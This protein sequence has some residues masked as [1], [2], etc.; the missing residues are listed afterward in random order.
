MGAAQIVHLPRNKRQLRRYFGMYQFYNQIVKNCAKWVQPLHDLVAQSSNNRRCYG[1]KTNNFELSE[2]PL[3]ESILL[4]FLDLV[5]KLELVTTTT[6]NNNKNWSPMPAKILWDVYWNRF[7]T[8]FV[9]LLS[10]GQKLLLVTSA[11]GQHSIV[12]C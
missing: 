8:E 10:S 5:T 2:A 6:Y 3:V 9:S 11:I 7:E 4:V 1:V 12:N